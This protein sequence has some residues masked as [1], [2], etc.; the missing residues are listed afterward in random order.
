LLDRGYGKPPQYV[1]GQNANFV[2]WMPRE[3]ETAEEWMAMIEGAGPATQD[4]EQFPAG[5]VDVLSEAKPI[6]SST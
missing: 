6:S 3:C 1:T 2:A 4:D 5:S